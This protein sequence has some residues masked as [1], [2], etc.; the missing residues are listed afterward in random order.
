MS[1]WLCAFVLVAGCKGDES[2]D[3]TSAPAP[4]TQGAPVD[5]PAE[6]PAPV[7]PP[8]KAPDK[9]ALLTQIATCEDDSS[10]DAYKPLVA[11][12]T[13]V[14]ADLAKLA[15]DAT[16]PAKARQ[17]AAKALSEIKD[18]ATGKTLWD[19]ARVEQD[20]M[21]R[22]DLFQAAGASGSDE[23][24]AAAGAFY[25]T[26]AGW[27]VRTEARK[28]FKG[29]GH[30]AFD[31]AAGA[32][33]KAT[34]KFQTAV[35]DVIMDS[36]QPSDLARIKELLGQVKDRMTRHRLA[37]VAVQHGD[38][39]QFAVL[40]D[41]LAKGDVYERSDAAN[42]LAPVIK[43]LPEAAKAKTIDLLKAAKAKDS[44]GLTASGYDGCLKALG[45]P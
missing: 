14:S 4:A 38:L 22:G 6:P 31:W 45:A 12:G 18:P 7:T 2:K 23:V 1:L 24:L 13:Q 36:A 15:A 39:T 26:D 42:M 30:K 25:L 27:E 41:G 44:G 5:K 28:A 19:A 33:V 34:T 43:L 37:Q 32:L 10:C 11:L 17:V 21:V 16:K 35:A 20:F 8:V 40:L 3:K 29:F 9:G